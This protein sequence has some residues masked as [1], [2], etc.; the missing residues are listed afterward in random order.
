[1]EMQTLTFFQVNVF[2]RKCNSYVLTL[3]ISVSITCY[4]SCIDT[5][6]NVKRKRIYHWEQE[7][8]TYVWSIENCSLKFN[9]AQRED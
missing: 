6:H 3:M 7:W 4:G 8:S 5:R 2:L 9:I 1:M